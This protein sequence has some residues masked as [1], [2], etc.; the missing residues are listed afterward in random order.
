MHHPG[1]PSDRSSSLGWKTGVPSDRSSSM[2][3]KM[4]AAGPQIY[5]QRPQP[6]ARDPGLPPPTHSPST[7]P[8]QVPSLS[9][10]SP[11]STIS[12]HLAL[13]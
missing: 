6:V 13:W 11:N 8:P 9:P 2:G 4:A 1:V 12:N 7:G 3:W 5:S 10:N